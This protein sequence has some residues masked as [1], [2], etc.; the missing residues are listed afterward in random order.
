[1]KIKEPKHEKWTLLGLCLVIWMI[2]NFSSIY[3]INKYPQY[4]NEANPI[5][6]FFFSMGWPGYI[7]NF[8]LC[9]GI[10]SFGL[11]VFPSIYTYIASWGRWT[12]E[13][14]ADRIRFY[15]IFFA[16]LMV[17]AEA[18]VILMNLRLMRSYGIF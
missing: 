7:M 4:F 11:L 9:V 3:F 1:M 17:G 8:I 6:A 12:K 16:G 2:D 15:R 14:R 18:I 13:Y 5:G 10:I